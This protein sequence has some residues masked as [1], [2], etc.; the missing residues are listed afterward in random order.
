MD[1]V[2]FLRS[3]FDVS[4]PGGLR[5]AGAKPGPA[6]FS[7]ETVHREFIAARYGDC[8][9]AGTLDDGRDLL[10]LAGI[11]IEQAVEAAQGSASGAIGEVDLEYVADRL[12]F[13][14][15]V[16][17]MDVMVD[18]GDGQIVAGDAED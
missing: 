4:I 18:A 5:Q 3:R 11:T 2:S 16:G 17:A 12:V 8:A 13:N 6:A 7:L 1:P 14:V 10:P 9:A 15:D